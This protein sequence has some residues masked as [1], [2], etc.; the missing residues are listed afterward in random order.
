MIYN[1]LQSKKK[2]YQILSH[3][4]VCSYIKETKAVNNPGWCAFFLYEKEKAT[5]SNHKTFSKKA[6]LKE[7]GKNVKTV[8]CL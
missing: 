5:T 8:M 4:V 7:E 3:E 6:L 1:K 2:I